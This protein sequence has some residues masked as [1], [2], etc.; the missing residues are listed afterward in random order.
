VAQITTSPGEVLAHLWA[1][2]GG[3]RRRPY[4]S[5]RSDLNVT[6]SSSS[7]YELSL[8]GRRRLPRIQ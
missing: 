2:L 4:C 6:Y 8:G 3:G 5:Q 7:P 1:D